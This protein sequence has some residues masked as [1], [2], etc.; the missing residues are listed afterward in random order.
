MKRLFQ[1]LLLATALAALGGSASAGTQVG[2]NAAIRN[3]VQERNAGESSLHPAVLRAPVG[4]GDMVVSGDQSGLQLLLLDQSVFTVGARAQ[5][6]IDKFVYD[7]ERGTSDVAASVAKGAFRF[8]SGRSLSGSG[9]NAISTPVATIGVRGTIVEGV[10][11]PDA[12]DV[13]SHQPGVPSFSGDPGTLTLI[14][15]VGP[16]PGSQGFDKPG[17]V[18][19]TA[20][21]QTIPLEHAGQALLIPGPGQPPIGPFD[22]SD[23]ALAALVGLLTPPPDGHDQTD[24]EIES[25]AAASG[26][27]QKGGPPVPPDPFNQSTGSIGVPQTPVQSN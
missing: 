16:G 18:D 7:P 15:L 4:L 21:G 19:V 14:V 27:I 13:L 17:A 12:K 11:G 20:D 3:S 6:T 22:L 24:F 23:A 5:V 8:M 1:T 25:A 9:K 2:V 26:D 10:V